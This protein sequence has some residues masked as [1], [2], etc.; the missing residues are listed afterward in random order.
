LNVNNLIKQK[1]Q[2][3]ARQITALNNKSQIWCSKTNV[4]AKL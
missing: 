2:G 1:L 4:I 3:K